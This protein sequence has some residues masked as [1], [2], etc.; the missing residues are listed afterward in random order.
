MTRTSEGKY[1]QGVAEIIQIEEIPTSTVHM[2]EDV[3]EIN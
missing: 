3:R 2:I 1:V